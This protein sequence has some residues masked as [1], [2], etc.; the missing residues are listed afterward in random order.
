M[1]E[2]KPPEQPEADIEP[3]RSLAI[4]CY[5]P[6]ICCCANLVGLVVAF[7]RKDN[8][9]HLFHARQGLAIF[10]LSILLAGASLF[11]TLFTR[12]LGLGGILSFLLQS[13]IM[14][15]GLVVLGASI[16]GIINAVKGKYEGMPVVGEP[17]D[18]FLAKFLN[19]DR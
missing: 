15:I 5:V 3:G 10:A 2:T 7:L 1:S 8:A 18:L 16:I 9:F 11:V 12:V 4:L 17:I 13:P 14:L 6:M 19:I